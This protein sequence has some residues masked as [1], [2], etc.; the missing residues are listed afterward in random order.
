M[1]LDKLKEICLEDYIPLMDDEG[2]SFMLDFIKTNNL[3]DI[4][5]IGTA[6][7]YSAL[8]MSLI[9]ED[10]R[11]TTLEKDRD[12]YEKARLYLKEYPN[13]ECVN[14][15]AL[16]YPLNRE[17]DLVFVDAAKSRYNDYFD[18]Y[19]PCIRKGG[20][21]ICDDMA[22]QGYAD[23][24]EIIYGKRFRILVNKLNAFKKRI[25]SDPLLESHLVK[26]GDG[27]LIIRKG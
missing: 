23:N 17:Y 25:V 27:L 14:T 9:S 15:D 7:G 16:Q 4:L 24:P 13:I 6:Y 3:K 20:Y 19:Y 18:Y 5:E 8:A 11:V 12:R 26:K 22:M 1:E 2:L 21:L 10:I